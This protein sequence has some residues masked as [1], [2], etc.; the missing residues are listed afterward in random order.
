[1]DSN[2]DNAWS[3]FFHEQTGAPSSGGI[4]GKI[5]GF[6]HGEATDEI[7]KLV[8]DIHLPTLKTESKINTSSIVAVVVGLLLVVVV[9]IFGTKKR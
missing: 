7:N 8:D 4:F 3:E 5:S 6:F 1:M 9:F 2:N